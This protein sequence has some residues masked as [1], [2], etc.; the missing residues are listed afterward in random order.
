MLVDRQTW[1]P[2]RLPLRWAVRRRRWECLP[3]TLTSNLRALGLL[4][5]WGASRLG[6]NLDPL[7]ESGMF[8]DGAEI[9]T[10]IAYLRG[11]VLDQELS[12]R[13][14]T[15]APTLATL[16]SIALPV[17]EFLKWVAD[18]QAR[19]GTG[20]IDPTH[21][22]AYRSRLDFAFQPVV[23]RI[24]ASRR[25]RPLT[26]AEDGRVRE[27][28]APLAGNAGHIRQ[29][30]RFHPANPFTP[31]TR[32]R[33][34]LMYQIA[35]ELGLR[36]SEMLALYYVDAAAVLSVRRRPNDRHDERRR[37]A[38]VK[39][40][41]RDLPTSRLLQAGVRAYLTTP[42]PLGRR[43]VRTPLLF[44]AST[45]GAPLSLSSTDD[46]AKVLTRAA[47]IATLSWHTFRHTW[48]EE[49]AVDLL[50]DHRGDEERVLGILRA[51]GGWSPRSLTPAHYIQQALRR[52]AWHYQEQRA[53]T[54]WTG[55]A[56]AG[57]R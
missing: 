28:V 13:A 16:A 30:F 44:V 43:G 2:P 39:R 47:G 50:A 21:L 45:T 22:V 23:R 19:G 17:R 29:P 20:I 51:L 3:N 24:G 56:S 33:N 31:E 49:V 36:R 57:A 4:Y 37:P 9:E 1:L 41:E 40:G 52:E 6:S 42:P 15:A 38:Y 7:L 8:L 35:R 26:I 48:A 18:P 32:L 25:I 55:R 11:R 10:L 27:L 5:E 34:W 14:V 54:L 53:S 46:V 12:R